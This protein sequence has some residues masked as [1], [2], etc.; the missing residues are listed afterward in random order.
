MF[1]NTGIA[2]YI[3]VLSNRKPK[4]RQGKVQLIDATQWFKP[5]RKNLGKK[6]CEFSD[7]DIQRICEVFLRFE[8]T[9]QAKIFP[10]QAFGYWKI[11]VE[12]PLRLH[13]Q[14]TRRAIESLRF[15][16]G[17]ETIRAELFDEFGETLFHDFDL[18]RA[19]LE[20]RLTEWGN[21]DEEETEDDEA[22]KRP[23][24]PE[25]RRKKLLDAA[26]WKRDGRLFGTATALQRE[27]GEGL[28]EDHN[29]FRQ[30]VDGAL[31]RLGTKVSTADLKLIHRAV[32]WRVECAPP[33]VAKVHKPNKAQPDPLHGLYEQQIAG[34][35][36]VVEYEP[37]P[38][39]RDTEQVPLLEPGGIE[40]F[41]RREVLPHVPDAWIDPPSTKTGYEISF[42]RYFYQP[43]PLRTLEEIRADILTVEKESE[44]LLDELLKG[45]TR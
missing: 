11:T 26:T 5:L 2:T 44:G 33:V 13:S 25:K 17:D 37:D 43:K 12:R 23:A 1:Y 16:S 18:A 45:S 31:D 42:T 8:E 27:L 40:T 7:E 24:I 39:L 9:P 20:K 28:F 3:W 4:P 19:A 15:A 41:F 36:C 34:K 10:N 6:N 30:Q 29:I 21:A 35:R 32:S 22:L 14:L 38:E